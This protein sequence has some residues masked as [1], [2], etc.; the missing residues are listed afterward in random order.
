MHA[1]ANAE[2]RRRPDIDTLFH[3]LDHAGNRAQAFGAGF[4]AANAGQD[5]PVRRAHHVWIGSHLHPLCSGGFQG[6][7]SDI[8]RHAL[9]TLAMKRRINEIYAKHTGRTYEE[10]ERDASATGQAATIVIAAAISNGISFLW[11]LGFTGFIRSVHA[12]SPKLSP[13]SSVT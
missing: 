13:H 7:A 5:Y 1:D 10:V 9:D 12:P 8:E 6:M 11:Y 4:E 2:E 3:G